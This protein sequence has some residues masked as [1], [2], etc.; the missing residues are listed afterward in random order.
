M[1]QPRFC[2]A[3]LHV[4][5][6]QLILFKLNHNTRRGFKFK[7]SLK[8]RSGLIESNVEG[9]DGVTDNWQ[10]AKKIT[11]NWQKPQTLNWKLAFVVRYTDSWQKASVIVICLKL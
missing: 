1:L 6:L 5:S 8:R 4:I 11:D 10:M 7:K 2:T 3:Q 9:L